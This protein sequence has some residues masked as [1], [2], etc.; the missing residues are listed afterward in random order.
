MRTGCQ[1]QVKA[2]LP[3]R[4]GG[5]G[6]R[7][8]GRRASEVTQGPQVGV[9]KWQ[10]GGAPSAPSP[11]IDKNPE[12]EQAR[13]PT[14]TSGSPR[15]GDSEIAEWRPPAAGAA[16]VGCGRLPWALL[17][18]GR[19]VHANAPELLASISPDPQNLGWCPS[20]GCGWVGKCMEGMA[21]LSAEDPRLQR[22]RRE[23]VLFRSRETW[24]EAA[25]LMQEK[26]VAWPKG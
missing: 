1:S 14:G 25:G 6:G 26:F 18:I 16:P 20:S 2:V 24:G 7:R 22:R 21:A 5:G 11:Y 19:A 4:M 23:G 15:F 13:A 12:A 10:P 17:N 3:G 8:G 9:E